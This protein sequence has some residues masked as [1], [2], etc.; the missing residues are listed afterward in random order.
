[1]L[2]AEWVLC[3]SCPVVPGAMAAR[4]LLGHVTA[5]SANDY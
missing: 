3:D 1:M 2:A 4:Q 5:E